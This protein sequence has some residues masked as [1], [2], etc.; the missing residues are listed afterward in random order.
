MPLDTIEELLKLAAMYKGPT[1]PQVIQ[2]TMSILRGDLAHSW[3]NGLRDAFSRVA[4]TMLLQDIDDYLKH[5][6]AQ[7]ASG[8]DI[9]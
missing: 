6:A 7:S 5:P 9:E 4:D 2:F 8:S 1:Q 3:R